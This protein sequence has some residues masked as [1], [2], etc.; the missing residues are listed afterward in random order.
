MGQV[1]GPRRKDIVL[2]TNSACRWTTPASSRRSRRYVM[3]AVEASLRRLQTDWIDLYQIALCPI[4][5]RRS[6]RRCAR[7]TIWCSRAKFAIS[8][9]PTLPAWQLKRRMDRRAA[10]HLTSFICCQDE[11]SLLE[12]GL[13]RDRVPVMRK[14][15]LGLL[16]Y[17]P[18]ASGLLT[19]KYKSEAPL[20]PGSRLAKNPAPCRR[21]PERAQLA[22]RR[23]V[24]RIRGPTRAH[25]P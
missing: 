15:G 6:R 14:H 19:G 23:W 5:R 17:F 1:L 3:Q 10:Q 13:E 8:A 16:P 24:G 2:A 18:L 20:P 7:S 4:R 22:Y 12:R 21:V 9:A 11:Y 25:P